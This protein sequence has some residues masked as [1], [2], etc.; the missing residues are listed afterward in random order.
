MNNSS[1]RI[2]QLQNMISANK[3]N[4]ISLATIIGHGTLLP[5]NSLFTVP[6]D[7]IIIFISRP[8]YYIAL[9]LLKESRMM[10]L[11]QSKTKLRQLLTD[12]LSAENTPSIITGS[13]W[14]WKR[15]IYGPGQPA[16]N[17]GLE[18]YDNTDSSW[19]RWYNSLCGW[20]FVGEPSL[21]RTYGQRMNSLQQLLMDIK[22]PAVVFVFGC[23]G[24]PNTAEGTARAFQNRGRFGRQNYR[25]PPSSLVSATR[26]HEEGV[27]RYHA[28]RVRGFGLSLR[29]EKVEPSAKRRAPSGR[30]NMSVMKVARNIKINRFVKSHHRANMN[31]TA[32]AN[33]A[34]RKRNA[35]GLNYT[36]A[37]IAN[38]IRR[39]K[40][41]KAI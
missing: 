24:D 21:H 12:R 17:M 20:K 18:L 25:L 8:G 11:M 4:K 5:S 23:R 40:N 38:A 28:K 31:N 22:G 32:L 1:T 39:L 3:N 2:Q 14:N 34:K 13:R 29:K 19:G 9:R 35:N 15:H 16:P 33:A 7:K 26:A 6:D 37:E 36:N 10:S 30:M 41:S 27:A